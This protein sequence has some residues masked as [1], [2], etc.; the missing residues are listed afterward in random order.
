MVLDCH[1]HISS[2]D[3]PNGALLKENMKKAGVDGGALLSIP[4]AS[5]ATHAGKG[6]D[7]KL[8]S[9]DARLDNLFAWTNGNERLYPFY[10]IDPS[11]HGAR[12]EVTRAASRGVTGFKVICNSFYP[13]ERSVMKVFRDIAET[14]RPILFHSGILWDGEPSGKYN[15]PVRFESLLTIPKLRFAMAHISWP[16]CDELIAMYGKF[17][18]ARKIRGD[19]ASE[20]FIDFTPGTPPIYREEALRKVFTVG[21]PVN[22]NVLFGTDSTAGNYSIQGSLQTRTRDNGIYR[23]LKLP[24][25]TTA[26][27]YA[28]N[29]LRFIGQSR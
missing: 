4:P 26:K 25:Q 27:I 9:C 11:A 19:N 29:F 2:S 14:G 21:Y 18:H 16:W 23:K 24:K 3:T 20:L 13:D 28:D 7:A 8:F 22:D 6:F 17:C 1:I 10:W 15:R 12:R 5:F